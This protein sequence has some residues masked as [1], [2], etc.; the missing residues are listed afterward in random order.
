MPLTAQEH[1]ELNQ[2]ELQQLESEKARLS[3]E[4]QATREILADPKSTVLERAGTP[5]A[6]A[7]Y[8]G[9]DLL[10]S[11]AL[12][13][14]GAAIGQM[15]G[16]KL[17]E[18]SRIP[19]GRQIG[20]SLGGGVGGFSSSAI[21][22]STTTEGIKA[23]QLAGDT[24]SAMFPMRGAKKSA[25]GNMIAETVRSVVDDQKL[26]DWKAVSAAGA[27][28]YA[29]AKASEKM[30]GKQLTPY[31]A[32]MEERNKSFLALRGKG[33]VVNPIELGSSDPVRQMLAGGSTNAH[34]IL[35]NQAKWQSLTR[36]DLGMKE[37]ELPFRRGYI[38]KAGNAIKSELDDHIDKLSQPYKELRAIS[39]QLA[40]DIDG[41][42]NGAIDLP[43][44]LR[45]GKLSA[46]DQALLLGASKSL[47]DL[48]FA[49]KSKSD[50]WQKRNSD[51]EAYGKYLQD[52]A[53]IAKLEDS[54][55]RA[56]VLSGKPELV[57]NL[58]AARRNLAIA[59]S[60]K[61]AVTESNGLV[62]PRALV[63]QRNTG[64]HLDGWRA[65]IADFTQDFERSS[66]SAVVSPPL[67]HGS[68]GINFTA[69][70]VAQGNP[71]G[72]VA[73]AIPYAGDVARA[74][75]LSE[76]VQNARAKPR[77]SFRPETVA[78]ASV[79]NFVLQGR[80]AVPMF[81]VPNVTDKQKRP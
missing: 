34:A 43:A 72:L 71:V 39:E 41:W 13:G 22:Q 31:A 3:P 14:G 26:P 2:L 63:D 49:R 64:T 74:S 79:R 33:V 80:Q 57:K 81:N 19:G 20:R 40:K 15:T 75:L 5:A 32:L 78:S 16:E 42:G 10:Q 30:T 6:Y 12:R 58:T 50:N 48:R 11:M 47:D 7:F 27:M 70:N 52:K 45:L 51:P 4:L 35:K 73:A 29:G 46:D 38:D 36:L 18:L 55:D 66:Q 65:K 23:G 54:L 1:Q 67:G 77:V 61:D 53:D 62:D 76:G 68:G 24:L 56:A 37:Q 17:G 60:V 59:Y 28:G 69:R 8:A 44:A 21:D 25:L 9:R